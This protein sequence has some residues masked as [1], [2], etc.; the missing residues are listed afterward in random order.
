MA[1]RKPKGHDPDRLTAEEQ[2]AQQVAIAQDY[3]STVG[4]A[5]RMSVG[6]YYDIPQ[7]REAWHI[8][9][10]GDVGTAAAEALAQRMARMGYSQADS[11]VRCRGFE[12]FDGASGVYMWAPPEVR[13]MHQQRKRAAQLAIDRNLRDSFGGSLSQL[14]SGQA[15]VRTATAEGPDVGRA[16]ADMRSKLG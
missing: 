11:R 8:I 7:G 6:T 3:I 12:E 16:M 5:E 10:C 14:N 4:R 13:E 1:G 9:R 2:R 15:Q